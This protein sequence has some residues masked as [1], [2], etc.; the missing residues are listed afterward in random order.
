MINSFRDNF[1]SM[2]MC[3]L[4]ILDVLVLLYNTRIIVMYL[5]YRKN[6]VFFLFP[7]K[8]RHRR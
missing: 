5:C 1:R 4:I 8:T 3:V 2:L 6:N 7:D